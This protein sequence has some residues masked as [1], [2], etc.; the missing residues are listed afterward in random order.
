[1]KK[2]K[3]LIQYGLKKRLYTK[4][5]M[6][7]NIIIAVIMI[8]IAIIPTLVARFSTPENLIIEDSIGVYV[9]PNNATIRNYITNQTDG[10]IL[11]MGANPEIEYII[12]DGDFGPGYDFDDYLNDE[13]SYRGLI[14]ITIE[15][16]ILTVNF[17]NQTLDS[18]T[19][20][21]LDDV[22]P[23]LQRVYYLSLHP[24][25]TDVV[26]DTTVIYH[27]NPTESD[28]SEILAAMSSIFVIP[29]FI[30]ITFGLQM[31]GADIIEEKS[32]KA[33]EIIIASVPPK[34]H[35]VAKILSII[36]FLTLQMLLY[37]AYGVIGVYLNEMI[38][39]GSQSGSW[40]SVLGP[41]ADQIL[42]T[43]V[44]VLGC[45]LAGAILY[46]VI[47]AFVASL[48]V[49]QEDY[50]QIQTPVMMILMVGYFASIIAGSAQ[51]DWLMTILNYIPFFSPMTIPG[52]YI[53]GY[54]DWT[55]VAISM[56]ILVGV[57]VLII[58]LISPLY[59]ASILNY[60]QSKLFK[61]ISNSI[62]EAK[63]LKEN[64]KA[65]FA[66]GNHNDQ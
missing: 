47:G 6:I 45:A 38:S 11:M 21:A 4:A 23:D 30:L 25:M 55:G 51:L 9:A 66:Q 42:P 34:T 56:G 52:S 5:F 7:S 17:Y 27:V 18:Y 20:A 24:E 1:M 15:D 16:D 62:K 57:T 43:V 54:I 2:L 53:N 64:Q 29:M 39:A 36:I 46:L 35:F 41:I 40:T 8:A 63:H 26:A 49:N 33:I 32:T 60:D 37:F 13:H 3:Y 28:F 50:Q 65:Y 31:I 61:R 19:V 58:A 44:L 10:L 48:A 22:I 14:H 59:R 12:A